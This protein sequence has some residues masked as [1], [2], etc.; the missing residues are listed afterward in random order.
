MELVRRIEG[1]EVQ[2]V[3][4]P[5]V[6]TAAGTKFGKTE[7]GAV[8]LD[9]S[10]TS[11]Y[12]FYQFWVNVDDRDART[13]VRYFTLLE[14]DQIEALDAAMTEHPERRVAQYTL[15]REVTSRV[16]GEAALIAAEEVSQLLFGGGEPKALSTAALEALRQEIP[17]FR[18]EKTPPIDEQD[19]IDAVSTGAEALFKSK[20][21]ARR[22]IQQ[23]GVYING[24][25]LSPER[26]ALA[27]DD[28]LGG[29]Y[30]LVRKGARSYGLV[31]VGA[32]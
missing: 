28:L 4:S 12:K 13:Y 24:R 29:K 20:G 31:E 3:T 22:M 21:D 30:V 9:A 2:G 15:A 17:Y 25:R 19:V 27:S 8:W 23:G 10:L 26:S 5:L 14:F 6:L 7:A 11:P 18:L 32:Q 16:H 1:A